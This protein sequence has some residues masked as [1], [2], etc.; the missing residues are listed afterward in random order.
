MQSTLFLGIP[1]KVDEDPEETQEEKW[2]LK[3]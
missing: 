3:S 1:R 2:E